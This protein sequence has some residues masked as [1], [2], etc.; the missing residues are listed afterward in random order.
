MAA[1]ATA[2]RIN[3][4]TITDGVILLRPMSRDDVGVHVA[5]SDAKQARWLSGAASTPAATREWIQHSAEC[6]ADGGPTFNFGVVEVAS[7]RLVGVVEANTEAERMDGVH[8]GE[9]N[10]WYVIYPHAR[11]RGYATRAV[12]LILPFLDERGFVP[13]IRAAPGNKRSKKVAKRAGFKR[14]GQVI[15][16]EPNGFTRL[17]IYHRGLG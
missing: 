3:Y 4:L 2:P 11:R 12:N 7:G 13:V 6:W 1:L 14:T 8:D 10:I 15:A 17:K 16:L 9:A 5:G